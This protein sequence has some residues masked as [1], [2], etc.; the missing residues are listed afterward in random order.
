MEKLIATDLPKSSAPIKLYL[1]RCRASIIGSCNVVEIAGSTYKDNPS[2]SHYTIYT[3]VILAFLEGVSN[4]P[5]C[6]ASRVYSTGISEGERE[7][8]RLR[9]FPRDS[10]SFGSL[11]VVDGSRAWYPFSQ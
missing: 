10:L 2:A 6:V 4:T 11:I 1:Y 7:R 9:L 5:Q 8:E 3:F